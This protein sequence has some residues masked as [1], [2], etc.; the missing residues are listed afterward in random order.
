VEDTIYLYTVVDVPDTACFEFVSPII[1]DSIVWGNKIWET[2][3]TGATADTID[4]I[5]IW[6]TSP[7]SGNDT[8]TVNICN[9][10][11]ECVTGTLIVRVLLPDTICTYETN[12]TVQ[13]YKT[14]DADFYT[15]SVT[16]E[17]AAPGFITH[18]AG[19][20]PNDTIII[21]NWSLVANTAPALYWVNVCAENECGEGQV[22][23]KPF[24]L[25]KCDF[26]DAPDPNY[27]TLIAN[28]GAN[29]KT[30]NTHYLGTIPPDG[31]NDGQP[32]ADAGSVPTPGNGDDGNGTPDDEDGVTIPAYLILG[33]TQ[34]VTVTVAG[35]GGK[36][37]AWIDWGR[38]GSWIGD[39]IAADVTDNDPNDY[40]STA[41]V[42]DLQFTV[43]SSAVAGVSFARFRWSTQPGLSYTGKAPNGEVEDYR[44][45]ISSMADLYVNKDD[46]SPTYTP[47]TSVIY[48]VVVGNNGPLDVIN[49]TFID[50]AP[51]GTAITGWT[52][53]GTPGTSYT[54]GGSGNISEPV[55]IPALGS[56]TYSITVAVPGNYSGDLV[57]TAA[58]T[59]PFG[60]TDPDPDN[61]SA[62]DTDTQ[63]SQVDLAVS[64]S[65]SPDPV[66]I[67]NTLTY[68]IVVSNTGPSDAPGVQMADD[69][70]AGIS[71]AQYSTDNGSN[72]SAWSSPL[73]LGILTVG[74]PVTVLIRGQV[75]CSVA[76][77]SVISNTA[78]VSTTVTE[79]N[80]ANNQSS[81]STVV[82]DL[83]PGPITPGTTQVCIGD[84][85]LTYS[86]DPV[87]GATGYTWTVPP[88]SLITGGQDTN[89]ITMTAGSTSGDVCVTVT[90]GNCSST[91]VCTAVTIEQPPPRPV[92]DY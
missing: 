76:G 10:C 33:Q 75:S 35:S 30:D 38:D 5:C 80:Y 6:Y 87:A 45:E 47:G 62:T 78:S 54:P 63:L 12:D 58:I 48:T 8:I 13:I 29:H 11:G 86:V 34:T 22:S 31:E 85:G 3:L 28:S 89:S 67:G 46:G 20:G 37:S 2:P 79:S 17:V 60:I 25:Q 51:P 55:S 36:L 44:V 91:P 61:N 9:D 84:S 81:A 27:P 90:N 65:D 15:W 92:F 41:G 4:K 59:V 50:N 16:P 74:S 32:S 26:G 83:Q 66:V 19:P 77:G 69:I 52:A 70:P 7:I 56:I 49:A 23:K 21:I 53:T 43:P 71:S 72:W 42:I 24:W 82:N 73:A 18:P 14:P 88:G 1:S 57:N 64:K 68:T 39:Q 40:N